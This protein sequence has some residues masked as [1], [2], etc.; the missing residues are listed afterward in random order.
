MKK[1][2]LFV[3][4]LLF[5]LALCIPTYAQ[6]TST[7]VAKNQTQLE[8]LISNKKVKIIQINTTKK[9]TITIPKGTYKKRIVVNSPKSTIVNNGKFVS[10]TINNATKYI[11]KSK[12]NTISIKDSKLK[13][14]VT[15]NAI[16]NHLIKFKEKSD[17]QIV[18]KGKI[19]KYAVK[20]TNP[21]EKSE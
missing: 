18:C 13:F 5:L 2:K 3:T 1:L 6:T 14:S 12:G 15:K 20:T 11:E 19:K 9:T 17:L 21:V 7:R 10:I 16:V 8:K 4:T